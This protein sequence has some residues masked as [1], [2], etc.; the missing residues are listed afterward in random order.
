MWRIA[1]AGKSL[2]GTRR[3]A[4]SRSRVSLDLSP[5]HGHN[6]HRNAGIARRAATF[7]AGTTRWG[8]L[9]GCCWQVECSTSPQRTHELLVRRD[10]SGE[11][12]ERGK[13]K[14]W[15]W[16]R[17]RWW[18][19]GERDTQK[20]EGMGP[21]D[22]DDPPCDFK[23]VHRLHASAVPRDVPFRFLTPRTSLKLF[24]RPE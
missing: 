15:W 9:P 2:L 13:K 1:H 19:S 20:E 17:W 5:V 14:R 10:A 12:G 3:G 22:S 24:R 6:Q 4:L 21:C 7:P 16:W 11:K 23:Y 8:D 18:K